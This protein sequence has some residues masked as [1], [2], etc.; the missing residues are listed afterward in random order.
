MRTNIITSSNNETVKL[1]RKLESSSRFRYESGLSLADGIHLVQAALTSGLRFRYVVVAQSA[2]GN[3]EVDDLLQKLG[4][5]AWFC[6]L[7]TILL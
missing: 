2:I 3:I 5:V 7:C 4:M 1:L 6:T